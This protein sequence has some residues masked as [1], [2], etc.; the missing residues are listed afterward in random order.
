MY[1]QK[2]RSITPCNEITTTTVMPN[3]ELAAP[4]FRSTLGVKFHAGVMVGDEVPFAPARC[5]NAGVISCVLLWRRPSLIAVAACSDRYARLCSTQLWIV[6][7]KELRSR[8][9]CALCL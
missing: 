7:C 8:Y 3:L 2:Q 5:G 9:V 6:C 4:G 1:V